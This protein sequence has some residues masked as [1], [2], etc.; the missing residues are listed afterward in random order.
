MTSSPS[1]VNLLRQMNFVRCSLQ[2]TG[3]V[4]KTQAV[5]LLLRG[6]EME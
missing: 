5:E 1:R 3:G 6:E 4:T 2:L